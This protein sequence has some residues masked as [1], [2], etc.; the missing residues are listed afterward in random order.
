[1]E[2]KWEREGDSGE[3]LRE[4]DRKKERNIKRERRREREIERN[5]KKQREV[6]MKGKVRE[7]HAN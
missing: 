5:R 7:V 3:C 1:M 2:L 4:R 6:V